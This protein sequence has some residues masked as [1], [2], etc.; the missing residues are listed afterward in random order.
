MIENTADN[1]FFGVHFMVDGYDAPES[2][3]SNSEALTKALY[4]IPVK[5]GMH[6]ISKPMV[7]EVGPNN[8]KD[9]GGLSGVVLIAESH[10]SFHTFPK[11]GFVTIDVYTCKDE[12]DIDKLLMELKDVFGFAKEETHCIK[13]GRNYPEDN[14]H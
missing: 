1:F 14:I 8:K 3:L 12:L 5:M 4:D 7:V 11:R 2:F 10:F 9:P 6:T 13:R